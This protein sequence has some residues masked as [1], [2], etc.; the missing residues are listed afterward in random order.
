MAH[1]ER[2]QREHLPTAIYA[3]DEAGAAYVADEVAQLIRA[4]ADEGRTAVLGLATGSTPTGVYSE[5]VRRYREEDLSFANVVTF[6][7]D[8]YYPIAPDALQSYVRYMNEQL[9]DHVDVPPEN[10]HIPDGTLDR[11]AVPAYCRA[12]EEKIQEAGGLDIQLLG[13]GRTGHIGF[14]EPGS[15]RRTRTRLITLDD[16]TR[17]DAASDFFGKENVPRRAIT[18]GIGTILDADRIFLMAW[19]EHKADVVRATAEGDVT[20]QVPA[21]Y[22]QGHPRTEVILDPASA[23]QLTRRRTPWQVGYCDWNDALI[24]RAVVWLSDRQQKPVL[25]LTDADY[26]EN[27]MSDI[28]TDFGPAYNTNIAVFNQLQH[29]ITGWPGG[30][31]E[32]EDTNRPERATPHPKRC[33]IFS[34]HPGDAM[35]SMGGTLL[36]LVNQGH[37]VHV[38]YQVSGDVSVRDDEALRF[39]E[40][41]SDFNRA[42]GGDEGLA[43]SV[44]R[45]LETQASSDTDTEDVRLIKELIRRGEAKSACRYCGVAE[46]NTYFLRMPFYETG[47]ARKK[48]LSEEDV[49]RVSNLLRRVK[50]HQ[51]YAT[52]DLADPHGTHRICMN[53]IEQALRHLWEEPWMDD[54]YVWRYRGAWK[55]WETSE[56]KMAVPLSPEELRY[57][58]AAIFKHE[59][60]KD[61]PQYPGSDTRE[62]WERASE[63][64]RE[65][66]AHYD[67]LGLAEYEAIESFTR[68]E[69]ETASS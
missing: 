31:P 30:K 22:L 52:G 58:Q 1:D 12:Y 44:R 27:G 11:N 48:P 54:C 62:F 63:R 67:A 35:I 53:A 16:V 15:N 3:S 14:N 69:A 56:I 38:A 55:E 25:K 29:T 49:S 60:Q 2:R 39:A 20:D 4:R 21:T 45:E 7:L 37:E 5:L 36:R 42:R 23:S 9:F 66:A 26:N 47:R 24:R 51:I 28:L 64:A 57:K 17:Q 40:F 41:V 6:N 59:S 18:M 61:R 34:P 32:A 46:E 8:E 65:T 50:P 19:G 68:W 10:V 33:L 43:E 13:I